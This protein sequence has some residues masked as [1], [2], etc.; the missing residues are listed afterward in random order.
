[1][2]VVAG[3]ETGVVKVVSS[4]TKSVILAIG[5][6]VRDRAVVALCES[7]TPMHIVAVYENGDICHLDISKEK[8]VLKWKQEHEG[9]CV[10]FVKGP[11]ENQYFSCDSKGRVFV[12]GLEASCAKVELYLDTRRQPTVR[13]RCNWPYAAVGGKD[14]DLTVWD[15]QSK[16]CVHRAKN[17]HPDKTKLQARIWPTDFFVA[18]STDIACC[19]SFGDF[20]MYDFATDMRR[21]VLNRKV[22]EKHDEMSCGF[23]SMCAVSTQPGVYVVGSRQGD[24][25]SVRGSKTLHRYKGV[26]GSVR[27]LFNLK[28]FILVAGLDRF[29]RCYHVDASAPSWEVFVKTRVNC[30]VALEDEDDDKKRTRKRSL[31]HN[32]ETDED[33]GLDKF[34]EDEDDDEEQQHQ[35]QQQ[36]Q[37][38]PVKSRAGALLKPAPAIAQRVSASAASRKHESIDEEDNDDDDNSSASDG[39]GDGDD[40]SAEEEPSPPPKKVG[41]KAAKHE[42]HQ[43]SPRHAAMK[44]RGSKKR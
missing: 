18:S 26:T 7:W 9:G 37:S 25:Y 6:P 3:D 21:P 22:A 23:I 17:V 40:G 13:F 15:L 11:L 29:V 44:A 28:D 39:D 38:K 14:V 42:I 16:Q 35:Q 8:E 5:Q 34:F 32:S 41:K 30:V 43:K 27:A 24:V 36:Q 31:E 4:K 12:H 1:M 20:R 19:T 10:G 33:D 2:K